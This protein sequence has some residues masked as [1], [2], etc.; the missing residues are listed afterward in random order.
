MQEVFPARLR[1]VKEC[2]KR[3]QTVQCASKVKINRH[4]VPS[5]KIK[6]QGIR[7]IIPTPGSSGPPTSQPQGSLGTLPAKGRPAQAANQ[8]PAWAII[9]PIRAQLDSRPR[10]PWG[11]KYPVLQPKP[12]GALMV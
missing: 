6:E 1:T 5:D 2:Q 12:I 7:S 3:W 9:P 4:N 10:W 11:H 8:N